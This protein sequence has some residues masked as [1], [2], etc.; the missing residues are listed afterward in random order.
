[1]PL[2]AWLPEFDFS[3]HHETRVAAPPRRVWTSL[4]TLDVG[5]L[6]VVR[7]LMGLRTMRLRTR[8]PVRLRELLGG[9]FTLLAEDPPVEII[10]GVTG[11][12]WSLG[13]SIE[14]TE[15]ARFREP[16]PPG[17][18]RAAWSFTLEPDSA[19]A[20]RLATETRIRCADADT[21]RAFGRYWRL[22]RPGSGWIRRE[23][24][25]AVR[26]D[27]ERAAR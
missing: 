26:R 25:R 3:E 13:G 27:A 2:D 4:T 16:P 21:R 9:A 7:V 14:P 10:L 17:T 6:T 19:G 22:I 12:F 23:I 24:L 5:G 1:M 18:A 11:R 20:T 8:R 15:R